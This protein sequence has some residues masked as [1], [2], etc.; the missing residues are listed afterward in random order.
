[1]GSAARH[2]KAV[3]Q[4]RF[5][6]AAEKGADYTPSVAVAE[7]RQFERDIGTLLAAKTRVTDEPK[8]TL[9]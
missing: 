9:S 6:A 8:E 3:Q 2:A 4:G 7:C 1:M 5:P